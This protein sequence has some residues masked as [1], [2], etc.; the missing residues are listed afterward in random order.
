MS[1][2]GK[3]MPIAALQVDP[4][5]K[6]TYNTLDSIDFQAVLETGR[7]MA[8]RWMLEQVSIDFGSSC[9]YTFQCKLFVSRFAS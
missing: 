8:A 9:C 1:F 3:F 4:V 5:S 7:Y 2:Q 6:A